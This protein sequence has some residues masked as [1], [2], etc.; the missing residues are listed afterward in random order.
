MKLMVYINNVLFRTIRKPRLL[1][2]PLSLPELEKRI[3]KHV[4]L[5]RRSYGVN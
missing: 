4:P 2:P 3:I 5:T 1:G